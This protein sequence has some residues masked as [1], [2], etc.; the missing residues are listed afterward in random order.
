VRKK[1]CYVDN[2]EKHETVAHRLHF[3]KRYLKLERRM[4]CWIQLPLEPVKEM[5]DTFQIDEW[6]RHRCRDP[7]NKDMVEFHVDQHPSFQDGVST[8]KCGG[9][10]SIRMPAHVKPLICFGQ[11]QCIFKQFT[12]TPK[13]WTAPDGQKAMIPKVEGLGVMMSAFVSGEF[14]FGF[15]LSPKDFEK[16]NKRRTEKH[17]S[18]QDAAK[19]IKGNS[20]MKAPLTES[21]FV[22]KFECGA[23]NQGC[24]DYDHMIIIL[25]PEFD[26]LRYHG[27]IIIN[28]RD[29]PHQAPR[30]RHVRRTVMLVFCSTRPWWNCPL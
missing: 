25:H 9:N 21:P 7:E 27:V 2:H 23:N 6:L 29:H 28:W 5:E 18:D 3:V 4:F 14:G 24:W 1:G 30:R 15:Y 12:F 10:L 22:V 8:T 20:P 19:K 13:A 26:P 11:D 16:V 17:C